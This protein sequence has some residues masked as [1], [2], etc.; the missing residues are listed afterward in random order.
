MR[1]TIA[2][3]AIL[4]I[5]GFLSACTDEPERIPETN[6]NVT[7]DIDN[8]EYSSL[9]SVLGYIYLAS[10]SYGNPLGAYN[11][12]L[13]IY[14]RNF[15]EFLAFDRSCPHNP[16]TGVIE[17]EPGNEMIATDTVCGSRFNLYQGGTVIKGP[18]RHSLKQYSVQ[19]N[20]NT[21]LIQVYN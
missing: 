17:V 18:A 3:L 15:D 13:L 5:T 21:R 11:N 19:Y 16:K 14:R 20:E 2:I 6:I 7:V 10:D 4:S 1:L 8:P 9:N 12:G